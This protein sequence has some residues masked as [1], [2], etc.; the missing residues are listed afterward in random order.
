M[1]N[2]KKIKVPWSETGKTVYAIV[3][4]DADGYLLND[5]DGTFAASP[6]DPYLA[7]SEHGTVKGL[8]SASESR[9]AWN[10]G[11]YGIYIYRQ[12]GGSP[13][14]ASDVLIGAGEMF[15]AGDLELTSDTLRGHA[16]ELREGTCSVSLRSQR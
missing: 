15:M 16:L 6:A 10:D 1:A 2:T 9:T 3:V 8:Y 5:A 14:P 11:R 7:L 4:R 12:S 13:A